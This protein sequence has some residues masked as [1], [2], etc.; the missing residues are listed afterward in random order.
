MDKTFSDILKSLKY[1]SLSDFLEII[2]KEPI[3]FPKQEEINEKWIKLSTIYKYLFSY[4]FL[5]MTRLDKLDKKIASL[6]IL[7]TPE[8]KKNFFQRFD[9][10]NLNYFYLRCWPRVERLSKEETKSFLNSVNR[11]DEGSWLV[12]L[13]I[14]ANT[15]KKVMTVNPEG[16]NIIYEPISTLHGDYQVKGNEIPLTIC[17][18]AEFDSNGYL[19]SNENEQKRIRI[20][21]EIWQQIDAALSRDIDCNTK[22]S[23]E[24]FQV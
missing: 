24:L 18:V 3:L 23:I 2:K 4:Y 8:T 7:S 15:Y 14:V 6:A 9:F 5:K 12:A 10:M 16:E 19:V 22:T 20:F 1:P 11:G 21:N 17:S 13:S